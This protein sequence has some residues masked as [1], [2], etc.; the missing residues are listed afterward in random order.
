MKTAV[1]DFDGVIHSYTSGWKG[2]ET[3]PDPPVAGINEAIQEVRKDGYQVVIVSTRCS[4]PGGMAAIAEWLDLH[5]IE[6]DDVM[7][8]KPP[9]NVYVDDRAICFTGQTDSLARQIREFK[10]WQQ[11]AK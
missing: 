4:Q 5:K 8:E 10:T 9:A 2:V 7:A 3:I 6:V 11:E 1:F